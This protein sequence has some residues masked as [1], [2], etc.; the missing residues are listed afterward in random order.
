MGSVGPPFHLP[1]LSRPCCHEYKGVIPGSIYHH[2][3]HSLGGTV[4]YS[5]EYPAIGAEDV[6]LRKRKKHNS[7]N[8]R[9]N[10]LFCTDIVFDDNSDD[11]Q[12][13]IQQSFHFE[14]VAEH[15]SV[16]IHSQV[17]LFVFQSIVREK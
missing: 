1:H 16:G 11:K 6:L 12:Q 15:R 14:R 7:N 4:S 17:Q 8:V 2:F 10:L 3:H 13:N 9:N 5:V